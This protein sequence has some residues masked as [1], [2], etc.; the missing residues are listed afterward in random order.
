MTVTITATTMTGGQT[1]HTA[2]RASGHQ[3]LWEVS[4]L[5]GRAL[6]R[7]SPIIAMILAD[8]AG[9]G[10]LNE[11]DQVRPFIQNCAAELGLTG[12][13]AIDRA[14]QPGSPRQQHDRNSD[15]PDPKSGQ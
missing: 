2:R 4:W 11:R 8:H 10:D 3:D 15:P 5:P 1:A 13:D 7:N 12:S 6:D 9:E 14:F